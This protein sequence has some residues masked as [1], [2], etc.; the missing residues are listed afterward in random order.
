MRPGNG[1][2][3]KNYNHPHKNLISGYFDLSLEVIAK[4]INFPIIWN[5]FKLNF[6]FWKRKKLKFFLICEFSF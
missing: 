1:A 6:K 5:G 2:F 3:L 4:R